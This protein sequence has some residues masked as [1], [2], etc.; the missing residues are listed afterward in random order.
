MPPP[1]SKAHLPRFDMKRVPAVCTPEHST[2]QGRDA[3]LEKYTMQVVPALGQ[4]LLRAG[5]V[6]RPRSDPKASLLTH[7]CQ[8]A[9]ACSVLREF[10][11]GP[12]LGVTGSQPAPSPP[13]PLCFIGITLVFLMVAHMRWNCEAHTDPCELP[14]VSQ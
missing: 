10:C 13:R 1:G 3:V 2:P 4:H 9:L 5:E 6:P 8:P 12:A 14:R 7:S 11:Q